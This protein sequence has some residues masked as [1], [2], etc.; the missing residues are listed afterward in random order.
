MLD[1]YL[2]AFGMV[3]EPYV[4]A[5]IVASAVYGLVVGCIPGLSATMATALLVPLTFFMP[6]V[7]AVAAIVT[8]STMAIFSGDIPGCLLRI[9]GTPASAAYVEDSYQLTLK[10]KPELALGIG[11]Y[12]SVIGGLF[13]TA[14]MMVASPAIAEFALGFGSVEFFWIVAMG[15]GGAV[16]IGS[17]SPLKAC[18]ALLLGLAIALI[19]MDNPAGQPRFTFGTTGLLGGISLI[20]MMVGMFAVSEVLRHMV[21]KEAKAQIAVTH[22]GPIFANMWK[23]T[24]QYPWQLIRGSAL[25]TV[26]GIQPGSGADMA[27]WMSYAMS[28]RFSKEPEKF[29]TGHP[30]GLIEA[31]ASNNSSLAGAWIPA[32]VF[33]IPGDS[34][35]AIAIG[36]LYMKNM[37]PGPTIFVNNPQ[38]VYALFLVFVL[39]NLLMLPLGWAMIKVATKILRVPRDILM[40]IILLFAI[41]GAFAINNS[42]F[43]V[44][45]MLGFGV[46]AFIM[47]ENGFPVA[48]TI[49]GVVLGPLLEENFI[50]SMIKADGNP[51]GLVD[52]P[53]A[54]VLAAITIGM[55]AWTIWASRKS[56]SAPITV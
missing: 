24:K 38:N 48:P 10:G 21:S 7:P 27:A 23:L 50:N 41:V 6:P 45:L 31:G 51:I 22:I 25:G 4:L 13:G 32:L 5:V 16:F 37:A 54:A 46:L 33:G 35:T 20:P 28:K 19:G 53:I 2:T 52:R 29:G 56:K 55:V 49:L 8:T 43:D 15:L 30:E 14:V 1:A 9:P 44:G 17:S 47:E 34:I 11:L 40:P 36:V 3:F 42:L 39:A 26:I 12:F 18:I